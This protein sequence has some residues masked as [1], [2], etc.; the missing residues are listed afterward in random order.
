MTPPPS[1]TT[2]E[3][4]WFSKAL[5]ELAPGE[6]FFIPVENQQEQSMLYNNIL[7][8][9]DS[10]AKE[11]PITAS[12]ITISKELKDERLWVIL[13]RRATS[14][15]IGY[16]K[17]KDGISRTVLLYDPERSRKIQLMISDDFSLEEI[18]KLLEVPLTQ[19]EKETYFS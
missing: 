11:N 13:E 3:E 18:E 16:K 5:S 2:I 7:K 9:R 14:P 1:P 4:L 17:G 10:L 19:D 12:K 6:Q 8:I 15:L